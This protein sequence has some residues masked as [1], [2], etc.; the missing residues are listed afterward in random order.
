MKEIFERWAAPLCAVGAVAAMASAIVDWNQGP[1]MASGAWTKVA[2]ALLLGFA[3][4]TARSAVG[5]ARELTEESEERLGYSEAEMEKHRRALDALAEGL[6]SAIFVCDAKA[7]ILYSNRRAREW[8]KFDEP[9]GRSL[10]AVT[11]SYELEQL[12]L[13]A[14]RG[15]EPVEQEVLTSYPEERALIVRAWKEPQGDRVFASLYDITELRKLE[16]VRQDFVANVS[17]ELRTPLSAIRS[18][19]ETLLDEPKAALAKRADYLSR[20]TAEVDR[21]A[22]IVS[23]LLVLSTAESN[24]VRKQACDLAAVVRTAESLLRKKA[25]D[26]GLAVEA[27][28]PSVLC[29]QKR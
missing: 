26:K 25:E 17:H 27:Q 13:S 8:F 10:M 9:T 21:L 14:A 11:I 23:D 20:I 5:A 18:L 15:S 19:A 28:L 16:R 12:V 22:T 6:K 29:H 4:V 3:F 7:S 2:A 1:P 24:P